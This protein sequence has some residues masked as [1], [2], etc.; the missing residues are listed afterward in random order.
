MTLRAN[1]RLAERWGH[2]F[3]L[4]KPAGFNLLAW[5]WHTRERLTRIRRAWLVERVE[6]GD[7]SKT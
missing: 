1:P 5:G 2:G 4:E 6:A 7:F 3:Q